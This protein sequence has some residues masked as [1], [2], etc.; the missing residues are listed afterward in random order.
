MDN[1]LRLKTRVEGRMAAGTLFGM[2]VNEV[3]ET[4]RE[5]LDQIDDIISKQS[6]KMFKQLEISWEDVEGKSE[7]FGFAELSYEQFRQELM[8][9]LNKDKSFYES[10]PNGVYTGFNTIPQTKFYEFGSGLCGL[11]GYPAKS[12]HAKNHKYEYLD[13]FYISRDGKMS[14]L[15]NMEVLLSLREYKLSSRFV[16]AQVEKPSTDTIAELKTMIEKWMQK[17]FETED[18]MLLNQIAFG[19]E[20]NRPVQAEIPVERFKIDNYDLI[21]WFVISKNQKFE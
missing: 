13:L 3:S 5:C 11:L 14:I 6:E 10:I 4:F 20:T 15:N 1:F 8:E 19:G 18:E 21:T 16:P 9:Q 2:E 7:S 17:K 12:E